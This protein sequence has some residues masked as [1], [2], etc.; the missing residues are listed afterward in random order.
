VKSEKRKVKNFANQ[1]DGIFHFSLFTLM[2][3]PSP[4]L[5][6]KAGVVLPFL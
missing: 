6:G 3:M 5:A 1:P 2:R 4:S